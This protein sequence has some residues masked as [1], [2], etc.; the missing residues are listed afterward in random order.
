LVEYLPRKLEALSSN[1]ST[2]KKERDW[3]DYSSKASPGKKF[4]RPPCQPIKLGAGF[5][6]LVLKR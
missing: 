6:P 1:P 3:E 4:V 5:L 2:G